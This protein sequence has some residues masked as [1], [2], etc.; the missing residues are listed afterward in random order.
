MNVASIRTGGAVKSF[1]VDV[2]EETTLHVHYSETEIDLRCK[3][4]CNVKFSLFMNLYEAL[5]EYQCFSLNEMMP[6]RL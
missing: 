2:E 4:H 6:L 1:F 5:G 3:I